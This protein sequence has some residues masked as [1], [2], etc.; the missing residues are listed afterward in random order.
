MDTW[1]LQID[2]KSMTTDST[3]HASTPK[4]TKSQNSDSLVQI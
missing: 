3:E 4:S 1:L 2:T